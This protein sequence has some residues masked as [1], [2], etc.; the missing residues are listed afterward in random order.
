MFYLSITMGR[1]W[2]AAHVFDLQGCAEGLKLAVEFCTIVGSDF[3]GVPENLK[4]LFFDCVSNCLA[5][6]VC[7]QGQHTKFAETADGTQHVYFA[8]T[9]AKIDD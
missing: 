5:A 3:C 2:C 7:K 9:V 8:I 1:V 6:L 4:D